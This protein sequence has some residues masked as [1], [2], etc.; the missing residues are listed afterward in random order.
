M[1]VNNEKEIQDSFTQL[2]SEYHKAIYKFCLARLDGDTKGAEDAM[3]NTFIM[4]YRKMLKEE[5]EYPRAFLYR[6]ADKQVMK[7]KTRSVKHQMNNTSLEEN[8]D[9]AFD[10]QEKLDSQVDYELLV[11]KIS[12]GLGE[13]ELELLRM[14]YIYDFSIDEIAKRLGVSKPAAAKRLQRLRDKI[15]NNYERRV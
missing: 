13:D 11:S 2:Y 9:A 7:E 10:I 12:R 6:I 5:I 15:R 8:R 3:Q 4:F 14:R 1:K